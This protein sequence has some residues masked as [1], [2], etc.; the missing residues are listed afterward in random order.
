[1]ITGMV[2]HI[3]SL[4]LAGALP[5]ILP[6]QDPG[7]AVQD[8][9]VLDTAG[10]DAFLVDEKDA[11]LRR[12]LHL[13]E[14]RVG[15]LPAEFGESVPADAVQM[16]MRLLSGPHVLRVGFDR[17]VAPRS[18]IPVRAQIEFP[19][20]SPAAGDA[21]T[22]RVTDLLMQTAPGLRRSIDPSGVFRIEGGPFQF[23][24]G[25]VD[26]NFVT[27]LG[28]PR[29]AAPRR[30]SVLPSGVEA[31]PADALR[32]R[33]ADGHGRLV[34]DVDGSAVRPARAHG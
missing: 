16:P 31:A 32:S 5:A 2:T 3:V 26:S 7:P 30:P 14:E 22:M 9:F 28:A 1:M 6:A 8:L 20:E 12:A 13:L 10:T 29:P 33:R 4:L 34:L 18:G 17:G 27:S 23:M 19:V 11:G 15:E 21:L 25:V 24:Y